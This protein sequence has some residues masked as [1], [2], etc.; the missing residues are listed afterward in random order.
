M[1][2]VMTG[3]GILWIPV[4]QNVQGGQLFL[5]IQAVTAYLSPPIASIYVIALFWKR[6]TETV[7]ISR[8]LKYIYLV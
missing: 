8:I 4:I 3:I 2:A 7:S 1:V 5:Y 6:G